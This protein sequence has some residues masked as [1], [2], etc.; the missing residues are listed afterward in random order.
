MKKK[1]YT[2]K[3]IAKQ[4]ADRLDLTTSKTYDVVTETFNCNARNDE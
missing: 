3:E 1:N 2:K 4:V